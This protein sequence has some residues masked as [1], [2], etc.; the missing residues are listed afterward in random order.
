MIQGFSLDPDTLAQVGVIP[1]GELVIRVPKE[2]MRHLPED[3][4]DAHG[5]HGSHAAGPS[6]A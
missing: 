6:A 2:L 1:R 4:H 3:R 5:Q